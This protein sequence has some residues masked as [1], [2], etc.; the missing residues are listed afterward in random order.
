MRVFLA[1][2]VPFKTHHIY[3]DFLSSVGDYDFYDRLSGDKA[4]SV[5]FDDSKLKRLISGFHATIRFGQGVKERI[6]YVLSHLECQIFDEKFDQGCNKI[7]E[8]L[9]EAIAKLRK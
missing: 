7:I 2:K 6:E 3:S 8:T 5:L 1:L 4:N 9:Y